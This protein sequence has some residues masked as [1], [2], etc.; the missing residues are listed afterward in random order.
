MG[1]FNV[2]GASGK[3]SDYVAER[4]ATPTNRPQSRRRNDR[5]RAV[6]AREYCRDYRD[7]TLP[8]GPPTTKVPS[9]MQ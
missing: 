8:A 7:K 9:S 5:L 4:H 3:A 1:C 2:T 6:R